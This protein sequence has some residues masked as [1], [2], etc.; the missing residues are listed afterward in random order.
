MKDFNK[1]WKAIKT[2]EEEYEFIKEFYEEELK[3]DPT[4]ADVMERLK[5]L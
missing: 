4:F 1:R 3:N 5:Y 2:E